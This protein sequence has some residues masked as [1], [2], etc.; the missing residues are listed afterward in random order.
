MEPCVTDETKILR[1]KLIDFPAI[2][3]HPTQSGEKINISVNVLMGKTKQITM[4]ILLP[5][6]FGIAEDYKEHFMS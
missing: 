4:L 6:Y 1:D 5:K 2:L 3:I